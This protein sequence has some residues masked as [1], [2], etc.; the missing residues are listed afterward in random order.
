MF[1]AAE[2]P[3]A[4]IRELILTTHG[5]LRDLRNW[6]DRT[7]VSLPDFAGADARELNATLK[8]AQRPG[9]TCVAS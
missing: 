7:D 2:L 8:K 3:L 6:Y 4:E 5:I 1:T 9:E